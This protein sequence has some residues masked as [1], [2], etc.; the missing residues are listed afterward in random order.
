MSQ[1]EYSDIYT[2]VNTM[3]KDYGT[4]WEDLPTQEIGPHHQ[5]ETRLLSWQ[6][7]GSKHYYNFLG[8][9]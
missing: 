5:G 6:R 2:A 1:E 4:S 8:T 7:I 9:K 3:L